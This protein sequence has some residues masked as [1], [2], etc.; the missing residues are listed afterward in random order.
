MDTADTE[1]FKKN[2]KDGKKNPKD[3]C[4]ENCELH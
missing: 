4:E 2:P 1:G 3:G